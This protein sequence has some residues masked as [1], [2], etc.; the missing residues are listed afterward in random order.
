MGKLFAPVGENKLP[1]K[2]GLLVLF[3]Q[4]GSHVGKK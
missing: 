3:L 4:N 2:A 1:G